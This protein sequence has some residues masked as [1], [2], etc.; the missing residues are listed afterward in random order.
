MK[1]MISER[2]VLL[3]TAQERMTN[4]GDL[5]KRLDSSHL[6]IEKSAFDSMNV[7]DKIL[8]LSREGN[9]K[10]E[11]LQKF[12]DEKLK[13]CNAKEIQ[14]VM[15]QLQAIQFLFHNILTDAIQ[16]NEITHHL[17]AEVAFQREIGDTVI[18]SIDEIK[19]SIDSAA[20]CAE[21]MLAEL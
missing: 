2:L 9:Q 1:D 8:N 10:V 4:M 16:A 5:I 17:E 15:T 6:F 20:A 19:E 11:K 14:K 12:F 13:T 21:F 3:S 7:S 18:N